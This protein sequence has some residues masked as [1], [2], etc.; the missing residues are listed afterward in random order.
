V[1]DG[2]TLVLRGHACQVLALGF[3]NAQAVECIFNLARHIFPG[4]ALLLHRLNIVVDIVKV[5]AGKVGTPCRHRPLL[6]EIEAAQ[7]ELAHPVG[8]ALHLGNLLDNLAV[9]P[10]FGLKR[11][12]L[13]HKK[14][15]TIRLLLHIE[16]LTH[17]I[18]SILQ[19]PA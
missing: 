3:G 6:K 1:I 17:C 9:Q 19:A 8:L 15:R 12:V 4:F 13:G 16:Y 10:F 11:V 5:D 2:L 14:A 7:A 18:Y